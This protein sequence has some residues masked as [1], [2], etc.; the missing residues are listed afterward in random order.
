[1]GWSLLSLNKPNIVTNPVFYWIQ[2]QAILE[3]TIA[4]LFVVSK[5][6]GAILILSKFETNELC[7]VSEKNLT[8]SFSHLQPQKKSGT[9]LKVYVCFCTTQI[10]FYC[11]Y[12]EVFTEMYRKEN[13]CQNGGFSCFFC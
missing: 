13:S 8:S 1:M 6:P 5:V 9:F 11:V 4:I 10:A 3:A 12:E 7:S 2:R